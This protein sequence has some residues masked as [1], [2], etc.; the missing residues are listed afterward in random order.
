M[1]R[2]TESRRRLMR[3]PIVALFASVVLAPV[4]ALAGAST[5]HEVPACS[6]SRLT[7]SLGTTQRYSARP[8]DGLTSVTWIRVTN[9]G[10]TC[11]FPASPSV[12]FEFNSYT[13]SPGLFS[14]AASSGADGATEILAAR[15]RANLVAYVRHV[16]AARN[17]YC[18]PRRALAIALL[19][20]DR[21]GGFVRYLFPRRINA[22]CSN[23]E[24][25]ASNFGIVWQGRWAP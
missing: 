18:A 3:A 25:A 5:S 8:F 19:L 10:G 24:P 14:A 4:P 1:A 11:R 22:V 9:G 23:Q 12:T 7:F 13:T 6:A 15:G 20:P 16:P 17:G 21:D 2:D